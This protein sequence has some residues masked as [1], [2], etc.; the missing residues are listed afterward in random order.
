M[1]RSP[2]GNGFKSQM[3]RHLG[4]RKSCE[5]LPCYSLFHTTPF[6]PPFSNLKEFQ[7]GK[8]YMVLH[9][10]CLP[11][12]LQ[13][14][15]GARDTS[16]LPESGQL[17]RDADPSALKA[18]GSPLCHTCPQL[19]G[20]LFPSA[21]GLPPDKDLLPGKV[22][23]PWGRSS[24]CLRPLELFLRGAG[25]WDIPAPHRAHGH[26][27]AT[28][29]PTPQPSSQHPDLLQTP[30]PLRI[31][32][33]KHSRAWS[34]GSE[35]HFWPTVTFS[36]LPLSISVQLSIHKAASNQCSSSKNQKVVLKRSNKISLAKLLLVLI[37]FS[38]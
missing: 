5:D 26:L 14:T 33:Q 23:Q 34:G 6:P 11:P 20:L 16:A 28:S 4:R 19:L 17:P 31:R 8:K 37:F 30:F 21:Q 25:G 1:G 13:S 29:Q 38:T 15:D 12:P 36:F 9:I 10:R 27:V 7:D 2:S 22:Q 35:A 18:R 32:P 3:L 24:A